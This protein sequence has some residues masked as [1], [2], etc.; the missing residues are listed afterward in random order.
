MVGV[1]GNAVFFEVL[2]V[3]SDTQLTLRTP[4]TFT[5]TAS[6]RYKALIFDPES[7][8]LTV[9]V[10]GKTEDGT[11]TGA[12]LKTAPDIVRSLLI[13]LGLEDQIDDA[14]FDDAA[15][16]APMTLGMV[17]PTTFDNSTAST[18]REVINKINGSIFGSLIQTNNFLLSYHVL[19]P[20]KSNVGLKLYE[21]DILSIK[22]ESTAANLVKTSVV[23]YNKREYDYIV[24]D[25]AYSYS[26][27]T[28]DIA[29]YIAKANRVKT[30]ETQLTRQA[31]A[32][33][34]AARWAF[35]L[36][37]GAGRATITT[38]LQAMSL[39]VG[40]VIEVTH[41]KFFER[42]GLEIQARLFLVEG[43]KKSG[44]EVTLEVVDLSNAFSRVA[45]INDLEVDYADA[46][47]EEKL[48]G[49]FISDSYGLID[50]DPD[51]HGTN[52][53]W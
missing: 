11:P 23:K 48:Y 8:V 28:S 34:S 5:S 41:R 13:D 35:I 47:D 6:G 50:N 25:S 16:T 9:D 19:S 27:K 51:S 24:K 2:S 26:Q 53:I 33:R 39:D 52:L 18:Y 49:G 42:I 4:A 21:H 38:K 3:E 30:I 7:D 44:T 14:S 29:N 32:E 45:T 43:V 15:I 12:L 17:S 20:D 36:E 10:L 31:D 1:A 22:Y 40:S 46:T 37:N